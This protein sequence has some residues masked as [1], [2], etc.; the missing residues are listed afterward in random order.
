MG[1]VRNQR[2]SLTVSNLS[3]KDITAP[4]LLHE[5][6]ALRDGIMT[7]IAN[8]NLNDIKGIF[9]NLSTRLT[10][11]K[12]VIFTLLDSNALPFLLRLVL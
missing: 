10:I 1:P 4:G 5:K 3:R 12:H 7:W 6:S 9:F 2:N 8:I 11:Y